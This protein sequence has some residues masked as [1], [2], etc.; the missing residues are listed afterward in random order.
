MNNLLKSFLILIAATG[1]LVGCS[2]TS[3]Q[4]EPTEEPTM[5]EPE[6]E[7]APEPEPEPELDTT[8][9]FDF[10][11][12]TLK[13]DARSTLVAHAE[14]LKESDEDV[15]LEGHADE[16]GTREYNMGLGERRA[17]AVRDFLVL[18]GVSAS[19]IETISYGEER[20]AVQGST[21]R[22]Y[23]QNRRVEMIVQ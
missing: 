10:D 22:A 1:I 23:S 15:R 16:R 19:R 18:Q 8:F 3:T 14:R 9:Y 17:K 6:P 4:E 12:S 13:P 21:E 2:S 5:T 20:P 7:P 11:K